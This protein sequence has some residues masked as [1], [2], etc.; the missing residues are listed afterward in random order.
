MNKDEALR[1]ILKKESEGQLSR[2]F[3]SDTMS[4]VFMEEARLKRRAWNRGLALVSAVSAAMVAA[5][6]LVLRYYFHFRIQLPAFRW[7]LAPENRSLLHF[8]IYIAL[9]VLVLLVLDILFRRL[10]NRVRN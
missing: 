7:D 3:E 2:H 8:F 4:R 6:I 10:R 9:L 5:G 1:T